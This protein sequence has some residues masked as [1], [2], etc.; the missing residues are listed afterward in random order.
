VS[1]LRLV[2]QESPDDNP[3]VLPFP[4]GL[5]G[6]SS[7]AERVI[8]AVEEALDQ[9]QSELEELDA[10]IGPYRLPAPEEDEWPP[11]AA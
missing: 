9:A 1:T 11:P 8:A 4:T 10:L 6:T 3:D 2:G 7:N 5:G